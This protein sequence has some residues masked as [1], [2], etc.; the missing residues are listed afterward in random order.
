MNIDVLFYLTDVYDAGA[1]LSY[2]PLWPSKTGYPEGC[3]HQL[4]FTHEPSLLP[5][6]DRSVG[7]TIFYLFISLFSFAFTLS[8]HHFT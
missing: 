3:S 8:W 2:H 4:S 5:E 1:G 6:A 7:K